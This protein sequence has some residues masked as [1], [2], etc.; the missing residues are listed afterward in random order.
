[1]RR[2]RVL[3]FGL[4]NTA[5]WTFFCTLVLSWYFW[6]KMPTQPDAQTGHINAMII[7]GRTVYLTSLL[8]WVDQGLFWG[9]LLI[10]FIAALI[11]MHKDPFQ[12]WLK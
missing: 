11:D 4:A 5:L 1:M 6:A 2:W 12:R 9:S 7:H 10:F 8:Y 3:E